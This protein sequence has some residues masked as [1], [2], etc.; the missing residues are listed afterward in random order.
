MKS[1][2]VEEVVA[3]AKGAPGTR[4]LGVVEGSYRLIVRLLDFATVT[5]FRDGLLPDIEHA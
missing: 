5:A 2:N 4:L 1:Q 3:F